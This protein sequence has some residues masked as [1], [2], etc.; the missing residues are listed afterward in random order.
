MKC[1]LASVNPQVV[2]RLN[3][4]LNIVKINAYYLEH[5]FVLQKLVLHITSS[6]TRERLCHVKNRWT[7]LKGCFQ[8]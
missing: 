6:K 3:H 8:K 1:T 5:L 4:V 2:L 7:H